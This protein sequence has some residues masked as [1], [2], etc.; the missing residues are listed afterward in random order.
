MRRAL[1]TF[2]CILLLA[3]LILPSVGTAANAAGTTTLD[4]EVTYQQSS[5]S[6]MLNLINSFR[7]DASGGAWQ[8]DSNGNR[9]EFNT[10]GNATLSPLSYD[11]TLEQVAMLRAAEAAMVWSQDHVRPDGSAWS[12]A[13]PAYSS[14]GENL[15]AGQSSVGAAFNALKEESANYNGQGH[16]RN[17]LKPD[18][19]AVG[20]G[21]VVVNGIHYWAQAFGYVPSPN[22]SFSGKNGT[23]TVAIEIADSSLDYVGAS[24]DKTAYSLG[25]NET[26]STPKVT[27][28]YK[29]KNHWP[30]GNVKTV[31]S[32]TWTSSDP[33]VASISGGTITPHKIGTTK[34]TA[35]FNTANEGQKTLTVTLNVTAPSLA[36]ATITLEPTDYVYTGN[37][38]TPKVI[39]VKLG[40]TTLTEGTDFTVSYKNNKNAGTGEVIITG[41][42]GRYSGTATATFTIAECQHELDDGVTTKEATCTEEGTFSEC[43]KKCD[44]EKVTKIPMVEH[45]PG[46]EA[47][48]CGDQICTVCKTVLVK[49]TGEHVDSNKDKICDV[50]GNSLKTP[51]TTTTTKKTTNRTAV[52][53]DK[54]ID[55]P[56]TGETEKPYS[57]LLVLFTVNII[58]GCFIAYYVGKRHLRQKAYSNYW[59]EKE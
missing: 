35:T 31:A 25:I 28:E 20:I 5:A 17:M 14:R 16:R 4:V 11:S 2:V 43:C 34:L 21:H 13:Y 18:Y 3:A 46:P 42:D 27:T 54:D 26:M 12:T 57:W 32:P 22:G 53:G 24:T 59:T 48:Y 30:D 45:T 50:C 19:N 55:T 44:Y 49:A 23:E 41:V 37:A 36:S 38:Y 47:S 9:V 1:K 8:W 40:D 56:S 6:E 51:A 15:A 10:P 29:I 7:T 52:A 33:S 58:A 39:S